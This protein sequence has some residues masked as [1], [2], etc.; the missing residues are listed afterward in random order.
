M[1]STFHRVPVQAVYYDGTND[2]EVH[3][4]LG[5]GA[6]ATVTPWIYSPLHEC[7]TPLG[8][9]SWVVKLNGDVPIILPPHIFDLVYGDVAPEASVSPPESVADFINN[10]RAARAG[11]VMHLP[12]GG[13]GI[14]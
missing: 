10:A 4:L 14:L 5:T 13:W 2:A 12:N 11:G 7:Y 3:A 8:T 6:K 9:D 1:S